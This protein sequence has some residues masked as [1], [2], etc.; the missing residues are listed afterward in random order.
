MTDLKLLGYTTERLDAQLFPSVS[1]M[2]NNVQNSLEFN[3]QTGHAPD[4]SNAGLRIDLC[5][6][7][8]NTDDESPFTRIQGIFYFTFETNEKQPIPEVDKYLQT[9]G[10]QI[11]MPIIRGI[12]VGVAKMLNLP[13]V[14]S[15]PP[16]NNTDVQ[17]SDIK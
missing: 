3:C 14:F 5:V 7:A 8:K 1:N 9:T 16:I 12:I 6:T 13:D 2:G 11:V 15:F 4:L 10:L 17:W